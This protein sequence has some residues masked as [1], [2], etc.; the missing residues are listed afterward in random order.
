V[1]LAFAS[2]SAVVIEYS[3]GANPLLREL[4]EETFDVVDGMI[5]APT[6]PG[7]GVTPKREFVERYRRD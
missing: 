4:A 6:R 1:Q 5:V 2:S 3:L 7:L